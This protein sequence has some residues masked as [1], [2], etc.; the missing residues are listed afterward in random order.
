MLAEKHRAASKKVLE[1]LGHYNPVTKEFGIKDQERLKYW[2]GQHVE[3]SP[4]VHNLFVTKGLISGKKVEAWK[5]KKKKVAEQPIE[6]KPGTAPVEVKAESQK[7]E[8]PVVQSKPAEE[9]KP[10]EQ[11][12][13]EPAKA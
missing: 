8:V 10:A 4:T 11:P 3:V 13:E 6:A 2:L 12:K 9:A 7:T 1:I 5:P